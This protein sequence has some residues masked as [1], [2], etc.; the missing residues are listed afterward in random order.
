MYLFVLRAFDESSLD[1][2]TTKC[3]MRN[4]C[5]I[6]IMTS[7]LEILKAL[8]RDLESPFTSSGGSLTSQTTL[9]PGYTSQRARKR[10]TVADC[11]GRLAKVLA[12]LAISLQKF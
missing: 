12:T 11:F 10:Q 3:V 6:N 4:T 2:L 9:P 7:V 8:S 5:N 1:S